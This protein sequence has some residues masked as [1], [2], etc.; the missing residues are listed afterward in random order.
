[1]LGSV[2]TPME[3]FDVMLMLHTKMELALEFG[4]DATKVILIVGHQV[5]AQ[6]GR[7][8]KKPL[9]Y[10]SLLQMTTWL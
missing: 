6:F 10:N 8:T 2:G 7:V 9:N 4:A 1:M 5:Q 3:R